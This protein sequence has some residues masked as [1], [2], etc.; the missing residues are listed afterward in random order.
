[1]KRWILNLLLSFV[2]WLFPFSFHASY[3]LDEGSSALRTGIEQ[4]R[5]EN[6]EEAVE[7]LGKAREREPRSSV[8]AF[9]LGMA[10]KQLP[11]Y[12]KAAVSLQDAVT[13][14]PPVRE[15]YLELADVLYRLSRLE[16][17]KKWIR[18]AEA[19]AIAPARLAFLKG[20]ILTRENS[21]QEAVSAFERSKQLDPTLAQA[22]DFQSAVCYIKEN[23]LEKA[24]ERLKAT[25]LRDPA[26]DLAG[27]ARQYVDMVEQRLYLERPVRLTVG[28]FGGYDTNLVS[29]PVDAAIAGDI[30]DEESATLNTSARLDFVPR[31]QGPWLFNA[32]YAFASNINQKHSHSHNS[33]ANSVSLSPGYNFGRF[34]VSLT[35][36]YTNV[37]LRTDP[38]PNPQA[39]SD[40]GYK[41][42]LDY[43]TAGPAVRFLVNSNHILEVFAG[44][45]KKDYFNQKVDNDEGIRDAVGPRAYLSWIWLFAG[46]GFFNLKYD[47]NRDDAEGDWWENEGHRLSANLSVPLLSA[48]LSERFGPLSLQIA[49]SAFF[50]QYRHDQPYLVSVGSGFQEKYAKRRDETYTGS[51]GLAWEF[52]KH[53]SLV[54]QYSHTHCNANMPANEYRKDV[55]MGGFEFRF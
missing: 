19:Q 52:W 29:R 55:Y 44:Y 25:V 48:E 5:Q 9:F 46:N 18:A 39:N 38:D 54:V 12:E 1:M 2:F 41:H 16:D 40:P 23:K 50:Q 13:L 37:L 45:D 47:F 42:Y 34:V 7:L 36:G 32:Q 10:C 4:Y 53:A 20:L 30:T 35:A 11:D 43:F 26:S 33:M 24:K 17:A 6:Y 8:A 3:A 14:S 21:N 31:L 49:G 27:F 22:A 28:I 15:A 51:A